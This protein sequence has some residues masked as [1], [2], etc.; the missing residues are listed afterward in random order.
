MSRSYAT[1]DDVI[2]YRGPMAAGELER[3]DTI[4][5]ACSAELRLLAKRHDKD[6]DSMIEADEDIHIAIIKG[7]VD[8]SVNYLFSTENKE[9]IMTQFS[10]AAGGYSISGTLGNP[11][12]VFYF[13]KKFL[14]DIGLGSQKVGSIE[15]FDYGQCN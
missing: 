11:G 13:P 2:A 8:A 7:V 6:L 9:P 12:G 4:L 15:V 10:Q 5:E 1:T 3:M 14:K